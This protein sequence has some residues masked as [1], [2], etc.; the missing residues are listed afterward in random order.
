MLFQ[1]PV[2]FPL[3][4]VRRS[5]ALS[6]NPVGGLGFT[7]HRTGW[8]QASWPP[9]SDSP[10]LGKERK[11][12]KRVNGDPA[13]MLGAALGGQVPLADSA[14]GTCR[15]ADQERLSERVGVGNSS[16]ALAPSLPM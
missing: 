2:L 9:W 4:A 10:F 15:S 16:R 12:L 5:P 13:E 14:L 7:A 11:S 3:G 6:P 8:K 1:G